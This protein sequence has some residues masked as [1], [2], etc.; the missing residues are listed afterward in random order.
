MTID[1]SKVKVG[2]NENY[3]SPKEDKQYLTFNG[4]KKTVPNDTVELSTQKKGMSNAA[5]LG[6]GGALTLA[7]LIG[8][9][10]IFAR[11]QH[12]KKILGIKQPE[13]VKDTIKENTEKVFESV[14]KFT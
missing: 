10:F 2:V 12:V 14:T 3:N 5:K 13:I 1:V 11:G 6:L 7:L 8:G 4:T 9:D